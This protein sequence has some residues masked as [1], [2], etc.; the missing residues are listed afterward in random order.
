[1]ENTPPFIRAGTIP[2]M[3]IACGV[4]VGNIYICQP[5]LG[6]IAIS[7]GVPE[8]IAALVAVATQVGYALGI[9]LLVPLADIAE[10]RKLVRWLFALTGVALLVA[11]G[12]LNI[13]VL[14][15]ASLCLA[16]LTV[17]PQILIPLSTSLVS[18]EKG[19]SVVGSLM[20]GR[21]WA[22]CS[23]ERFRVSSRSTAAH[24]VRPLAW[25]VFS[26]F[27]FFCSC[28]VSCPWRKPI[29]RKCITASCLHRFRRF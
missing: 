3:A 19:G 15:A 25:R 6:Q 26:P 7:F 22:F 17:I 14:V 28:R 23:P 4:M 24:G 12:A 2:V 10:P 27:P 16:V 11:A 9:L 21:F 18:P 20:M 13:P 1:M 8:R 5:L 29:A